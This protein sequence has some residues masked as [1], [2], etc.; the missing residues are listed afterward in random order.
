MLMTS[1]HIYDHLRVVEVDLANPDVCTCGNQ[2][3]FWY[4][5]RKDRLT[6]STYVEIENPCSS[7]YDNAMQK[8]Y[9]EYI[10]S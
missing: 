10:D 5:T 1:S 3:E 7:C 2:E 6:G 9:E 4:H 8:D